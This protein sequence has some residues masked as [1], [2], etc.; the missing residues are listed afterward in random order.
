MKNLILI[1]IML[2]I[3]LTG[4]SSEKPYTETEL[5]GVKIVENT[6]AGIEPDFNVN[7][8]HLYTIQN[9]END[10]SFVL[11]FPGD[12][13]DLNSDIDSKLNLYVVD[14]KRSK[15][16][17]FDKNGKFVNDWGRK[18]QGPGE[19]PW[20]PVDIFVSEKDTTVYVY[21][22]SGRL[23]LFDL[24]GNFKK[25]F[26]IQGKNMR[27]SNFFMTDNGPLFIGETYEGQWGTDEFK[28]GKCLYN[29]T[30]EFGIKDKIY[31]HLEPFDMKQIDADDQGLMTAINDRSI[32]IAGG[33]KTE[34]EIFRFDYSG[35]KISEIKKKYAPLRR[36][37]EELAEIKEALEKF[38]QKMNGQIQFK[39]VSTLRSVITQMFLDHSNNLWVS[40]NESMFNEEGQQFDIFNNEGHFLKTVSVPELTGL[41]V[42]SKGKYII[43][44]TPIEENY[45]ED[46]KADVVIKVFELNL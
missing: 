39:E 29:A 35:K 34:Y 40:V 15:I 43:A 45:S 10:T 18:G 27:A 21:D 22:G 16:L 46:G 5:N 19:F 20:N 31:G 17:K 24:E 26:N 8:K 7:F 33:T 44:A 11:N 37:K 36:S 42:R 32:Y 3:I 12:R 30:P 23:S 28:M 6:K 4:C 25:F 14:N 2:S 41:K 1:T 13:N 9:S 38:T